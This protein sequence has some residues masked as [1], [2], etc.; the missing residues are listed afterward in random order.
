MASLKQREQL[1]QI[2][3]IIARFP[4]GARL[5][6]IIDALNDGDQGYIP[7]RRTL[8]SWLKRWVDDGYLYTTGVQRGVRYFLANAPTPLDIDS[9]GE[10]SASKFPFTKPTENILQAIRKPLIQRKP[11]AYEF[12]FLNAYRPN[13]SSY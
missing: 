10:L 5:V 12:D 6:D 3:A 9:A 7:P 8:Q 2:D 4:G 11:V 13:A 1:K